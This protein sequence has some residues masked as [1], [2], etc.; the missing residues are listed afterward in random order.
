MNIFAE[1]K[2]NEEKEVYENILGKE[3]LSRK[4]GRF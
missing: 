4:K 3:I 2:I 1:T